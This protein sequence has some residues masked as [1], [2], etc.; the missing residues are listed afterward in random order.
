M[1]YKYYERKINDVIMMCPIE[2]GIEILVYNVLDYILES[3]EVSLVD[4]NRL[5]KDRDQRL[6]TDAGV[7]DIAVLSEDFKYRSD[8]GQVY[9]FIEVKATSKDLSETEQIQGQRVATKHYLC[10]NGLCWN[11]FENNLS[12]PKWEKTLTNSDIKYLN[13][14]KSVSIDEN[15]FLDLL[16]TLD[17]IKWTE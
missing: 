10:T 9:G 15:K 2:A 16:K 8:I 11:Y 6:T 7:S 1:N 3:K 12:E 4:I 17:A 14:A 13:Q 5:R